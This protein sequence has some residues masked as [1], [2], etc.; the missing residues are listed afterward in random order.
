M[1]RVIL[2]AQPFPVARVSMMALRNGSRI[3]F[4][5]GTSSSP[6]QNQ[7][8]KQWKHHQLPNIYRL[9]PARIHGTCRHGTSLQKKRIE[10]ACVH[11]NF[12]HVIV[13]LFRSST[14]T[15]DLGHAV[16]HLVNFVG[17]ADLYVE[18]LSFLHFSRHGSVP[19]SC[20]CGGVGPLMRKITNI[21]HGVPHHD[22]ADL[23]LDLLKK[24]SSLVQQDV[25]TF[26]LCSRA[27]RTGT[28][29]CIQE[30]RSSDGVWGSAEETVGSDCVHLKDVDMLHQRCT[31][32]AN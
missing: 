13:L 8:I 32:G 2:T 30:H 22:I 29:Q 14:P 5:C 9:S 28:T 31:M 12:V 6:I 25:H 17:I 27:L 19:Q 1:R 15:I 10:Q 20:A 21:T 23:P 3:F 4:S 24:M 18:S 11:S 7:Y 16:R 26:R